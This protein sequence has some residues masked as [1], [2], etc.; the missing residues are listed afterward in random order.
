MRTAFY[1]YVSNPTR[2]RRLPRGGSNPRR[3]AIRGSDIKDFAI[4]ALANRYLSCA[5]DCQ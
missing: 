3:G 1:M 2:H 5:D 4:L